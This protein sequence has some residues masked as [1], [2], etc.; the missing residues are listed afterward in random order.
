MF[1]YILFAVVFCY[2]ESILAETVY[3]NDMLFVPLR[4]G[5]SVEHKILHK[6]ISSGTALELLEENEDTGYSLIRMANGQEGWLK[7]QYL[8]AT[9]IALDRLDGLEQ[10]IS[11]LHR[12]SESDQQNIALLESQ[13]SALEQANEKLQSERGVLNSEVDRITKLS[14][15]VIQIDQDNLHLTEQ[16]KSLMDEL[17]TLNFINNRLEDDSDRRWF[18]N[19]AGAVLSGLLIGFWIGRQ[20]YLR[21]QSGGWS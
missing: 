15:D 5:Q 17:D 1:R 19:G 10:Q 2:V 12:D 13:I 3:V 21:T 20:I 9:P 14:E 16:N 8:T 4:G 6:G 7:S 18:L 11:E